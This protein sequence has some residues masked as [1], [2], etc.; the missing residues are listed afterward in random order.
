MS[1]NTLYRN[2]R[3]GQVAKLLSQEGDRTLIATIREN[4]ET[5][6]TRTVPTSSI[7]KDTLDPDGE[8]HTRGYVP[9]NV[10]PAGT[11]PQK[12]TDRSSMELDLMDNLDE[13]D[14]SQL[15]AV[16]LEQQKVKSTAEELVN[17]AKAIV[18]R[19]R[20]DSL[21]IDIQSGIALVYTSGTKFDA[22]TAQRNLQPEDFQRILL[23]KPDATLARR[24]FEHEPEK[25]QA[26]LKD[27]GATLTVRE[28]T[29]ED[30]S[31]FATSAPKGDEDFSYEV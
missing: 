23:P 6:R 20:G 21:G 17:R 30:K 16:I 15:A 25:L 29:D 26:C 22:K 14:D 9:L 27:N 13:L 11:A 18:K 24:I 10:A 28:A 7:H 19:R 1:S 31:R 8:S 5:G 3:S 2:V 12:S 4:G